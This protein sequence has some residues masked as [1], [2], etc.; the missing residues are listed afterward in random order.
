VF[1]VFFMQKIVCAIFPGVVPSMRP[2]EAM[3]AVGFFNEEKSRG[4]EP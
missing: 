1:G 2:A 4:K 3:F